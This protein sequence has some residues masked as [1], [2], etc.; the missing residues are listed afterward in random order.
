MVVQ[1]RLMLLEMFCKRENF[2]YLTVPKT[3]AQRLLEQPHLNSNDVPVY[4]ILPNVKGS[5][6]NN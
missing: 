6:A 1:P 5:Q 2:V 3:Q 4:M